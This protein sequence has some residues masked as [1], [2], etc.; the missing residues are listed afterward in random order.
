MTGLIIHFTSK[1][2][3]EDIAPADTDEY[4]FAS[5]C[6]VLFR[7]KRQSQSTF[8]HDD[9]SDSDSDDDDAVAPVNDQF[10]ADFE[11]A[12]FSQAP[13]QENFADVLSIHPSSNRLS[14]LRLTRRRRFQNKRREVASLLCT[15]YTWA[16]VTL[17]EPSVLW[18]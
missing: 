7:S 9:D 10:V 15:S 5:P 11:A 6:S 13:V 8:A 16:V 3:N 14:F 1:F 17:L 4:L 2:I 18:P 12:E